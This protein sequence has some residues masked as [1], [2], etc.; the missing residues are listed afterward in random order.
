MS[1]SR[2]TEFVT[3]RQVYWFYL[4]SKGCGLSEIGRM[5][6]WTHSTVYHGIQK[7]KDLISVNDPYIQPFLKA[8]EK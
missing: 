3:A 5:F 2:K 1:R 8:I 6:G 4:R 7:I